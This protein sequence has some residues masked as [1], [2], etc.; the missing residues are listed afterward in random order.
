MFPKMLLV[1]AALAVFSLL[2]MPAVQAQNVPIPLTGAIQNDLLVQSGEDSVEEIDGQYDDAQTD[3]TVVA[4]NIDQDEAPQ[5]IQ[6]APIGQIGPMINTGTSIDENETNGQND[7][8]DAQ[9]N[10]NNGPNDEDDGGAGD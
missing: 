2:A 9:E 4:Y 7:E 3:D 1:G 6:V 5:P 8:N 10:D